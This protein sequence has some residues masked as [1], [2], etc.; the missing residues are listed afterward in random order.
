MS[1]LLPFVMQRK[2]P[3]TE[4]ITHVLPLQDAVRAYEI[5]ASRKESAIKVLLKP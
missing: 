5:F 3:L 2:L 4:I 1:E